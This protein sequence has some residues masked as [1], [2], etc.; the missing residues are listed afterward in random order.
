[1]ISLIIPF[2]A[3]I[4][5][6]GATFL[7]CKRPLSGGRARQPDGQQDFLVRERAYVASSIGIASLQHAEVD[8]RLADQVSTEVLLGN[9]YSCHRCFAARDEYDTGLVCS[10][11]GPIGSGFVK[12]LANP[13]E[14][15]YWLHV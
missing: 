14:N 13:E 9:Y 12:S 8:F 5:Q 1:M 4:F 10:R 11:V 3:S 2:L 15:S 6:C 7:Q